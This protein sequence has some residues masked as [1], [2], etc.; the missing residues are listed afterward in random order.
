MLGIGAYQPFE[1]PDLRSC[2]SPFVGE[3]VARNIDLLVKDEATERGFRPRHGGI[4]RAHQQGHVIS[5]PLACQGAVSRPVAHRHEKHHAK[6]DERRHRR[7][8]RSAEPPVEPA[9]VG[10]RPSSPLILVADSEGHNRPLM[11]LVA[12]G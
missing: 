10:P 11:R 12:D 8:G 4:D 1:L 2:K 3:D 6:E 5:M 9:L 7:P